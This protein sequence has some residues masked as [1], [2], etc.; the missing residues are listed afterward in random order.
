M[1]EVLHI[2]SSASAPWCSWT[3]LSLL[4]CAVLS[5][6]FQP[7]VI[8]QTPASLAVRN[9]RTYKESP[10]NLMGQLLITLFR[11]GTVSMALCLCQCPE[12]GFSFIMFAVACGL[13]LAVL[14]LKM[15]CNSLLD[16][17]FMFSRQFGAQ[18]EHYGNLFTLATV[19]LYPVVLVLMRMAAPAAARWCLAFVTGLFVITWSYRCIRTYITSPRAVLYL[20]LYVFTLEILP[21][22]GIA[23]IFAKIIVIL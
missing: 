5:E 11:I 22:A 6:W 8:I 19:V 18:Y 3:M 2:V 17:T 14:G 16:Y 20:L 23:Y 9:D 13:V 15:L 12:R 1:N 7:G 4:L 10:V 21:F